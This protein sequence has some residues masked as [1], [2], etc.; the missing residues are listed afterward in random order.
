MYDSC[1]NVYISIQIGVG[2]WLYHYRVNKKNCLMFNL[3][4]CLVFIQELM[5]ISTNKH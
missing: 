4:V 1:L 2:T 3:N 5:I